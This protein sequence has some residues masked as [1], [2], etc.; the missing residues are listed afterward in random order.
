M[1][2]VIISNIGMLSVYGHISL[3]RAQYTSAGLQNIFFLTWNAFKQLGRNGLHLQRVP[4][5]VVIAGASLSFWRVLGQRIVARS[6]CF[7]V[8]LSLLLF[9]VRCAPGCCV[10]VG[11]I[12]LFSR[13]VPGCC[14]KMWERPFPLSSHQRP[15][16]WGG[17][18]LCCEV[19]DEI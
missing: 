16:L 11:G 13:R 4:G 19:L 5:C 10:T 7:P 15:E 2:A 9:I 18:T 12:A 3:C 6:T 8:S 17:A 14:H 1:D